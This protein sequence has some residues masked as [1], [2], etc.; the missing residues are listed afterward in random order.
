MAAIKCSAR[1]RLRS[2]LRSRFT[3][4]DDNS[5]LSGAVQGADNAQ[6][7]LHLSKQSIN[8]LFYVDTLS[9]SD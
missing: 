5:V 9:L 2:C 6:T 3:A 8:P 4:V 1:V 7:P